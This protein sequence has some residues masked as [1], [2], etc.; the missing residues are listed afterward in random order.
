M[1]EGHTIH[2]AARQQN[3]A[4]KG[5]TIAV[6]SPQGR[7]AADA[8]RIDGAVLKRVE[9]YGKH[10]F[11]HWD[12]GEIGHVH[13]GLFGRFRTSY[14][15]LG[16]PAAPTGAVRMRLSTTTDDGPVDRR[17]VTI[18]L[19]GPTVCSLDPPDARKRVLARLGPDPLARKPDPAPMF[20]RIRRSQRP[21]ADLLLDQAV[22]AGIG[23]VYRAE[24][25]FVV[26]IH[27]LR[28]GRDLDDA[29]LHA[30][31]ATTCGML[32]QGLRDGRIVTVD[33]AELGLAPGARRPRGEAT[34]V[35]KRGTCLRCGDTISTVEAG[36]RPCYYCPTDQPR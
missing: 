17:E 8:A 4:L 34:Y 12:T 35:Y 18:D 16:D 2:R 20:D 9:P 6:S 32:A 26:G 28:P 11:F 36:G 7:F 3:R 5:R 22:V 10:L 29:E 1:P 14:S 15:A 21:I 33:R 24:I 30:I 31:W 19:S 23:N 27:P 13:L 25:L